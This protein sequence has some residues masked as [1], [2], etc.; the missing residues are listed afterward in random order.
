MALF[1]GIAQVQLYPPDAAPSK[2][3]HL[4]YAELGAG[5]GLTRDGL[6]NSGTAVEVRRLDFQEEGLQGVQQ[7]ET[8]G[9]R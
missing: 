1:L 6:G 2:N 3:T 9:V 4:H 8:Q 7:V 5:A